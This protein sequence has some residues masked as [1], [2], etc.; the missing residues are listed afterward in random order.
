M[1]ARTEARMLA[2]SFASLHLMDVQT[3]SMAQ[4]HD[5]HMR[6]LDAAHA[7]VS[8]TIARLLKGDVL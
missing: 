2:H 1:G 4:R 8:A 7:R 3:R 6:D 5:Q